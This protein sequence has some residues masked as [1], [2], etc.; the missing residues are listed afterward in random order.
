MLVYWTER[1]MSCPGQ[2]CS[3]SYCALLVRRESERRERGRESERGREG[4][5]EGGRELMCEKRK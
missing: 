1:P 4:G 5:R 3:F 2:N